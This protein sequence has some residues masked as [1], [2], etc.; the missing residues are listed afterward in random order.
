MTTGKQRE[1][2]VIALFPVQVNL[3][4]RVSVQKIDSGFTEM[5]TDRK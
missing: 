2:N 5:P 4:Q 1:S 3:P